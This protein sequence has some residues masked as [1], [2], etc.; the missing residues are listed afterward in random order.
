[1]PFIR[2]PL[3]V[4]VAV[5]YNWNGKL[6][7]NIY[8]VLVEVPVTTIILDDIADVFA[9]WVINNLLDWMNEEI[10]LVA[11]TAQSLD[12]EFGAKVTYP[13]AP[14]ETGQIGGDAVT[15]NVAIVISMQTAKTGR[16]FRGRSYVAGMSESGIADNNLADVTLA[17]LI[18]GFAQ[19]V[20]TLDASDYTLVVA[21][22]ETAGSPRATAIGTPVDSFASNTRV[23]T[24]RRRLPKV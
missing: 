10:S 17:G 6:V 1:M 14:P 4:R 19:L 11:V 2:L 3:G 16:S 23:D 22:F 21:S 20:T 24:Q 12:E 18:A 15:N 13:V 8:H 9:G 7:V 5:E